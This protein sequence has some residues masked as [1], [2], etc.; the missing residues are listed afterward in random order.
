VRVR[1]WTRFSSYFPQKK[2]V[3]WHGKFQTHFLCPH[4]FRMADA[5][6]Q[7]SVPQLPKLNSNGKLRTTKV[8]FFLIVFCTVVNI[9][10][11][12]ENSMT[13]LPTFIKVQVWE[14]IFIFFYFCSFYNLI[15]LLLCFVSVW[16]SVYLFRPSETSGQSSSYSVF[17]IQMQ[18]MVGGK[19]LI[20]RLVWEQRAEKTNGEETDK[21][22]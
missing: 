4:K 12:H 5:W 21:F 15:S 13:V 19:R 7:I 10:S 2:Y 16:S 6:C 3:L 14:V 8:R 18:M 9:L 1:I 22:E 11:P 17:Y 20:L